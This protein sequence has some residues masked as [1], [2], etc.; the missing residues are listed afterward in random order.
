MS[1][2]PILYFV[3]DYYAMLQEMKDKKKEKSV[4]PDAFAAI[5]KGI[6]A[7]KG[8][9]F[10]F[11][12]RIK[13]FNFVK[14]DIEVRYS[15][16]V[17]ESMKV[18][19]NLLEE[20]KIDSSKGIKAIVFERQVPNMQHLEPVIKD[21]NGSFWKAITSWRMEVKTTITENIY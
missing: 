12:I 2:E 13:Y 3:E 18:V 20:V 21:E 15:N 17:M 16:S 6:A 4:N 14:K 10:P 19:T 11:R 9:T 7:S 8:N 5:A 1:K